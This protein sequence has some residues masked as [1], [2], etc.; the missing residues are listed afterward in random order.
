[1][2]EYG[3]AHGDLKG[4]NVLI[5]D[6][7]KALISDFGI[8][9]LQE[10]IEQAPPTMGTVRKWGTVNI[11]NLKKALKE[12]G[13]SQDHAQSLFSRVSNISRSGGGTYRWMA[14]ERLIPEKFGLKSANAT[15]ASDVFS[16]GMLSIEVYTGLPPYHEF[17]RQETAILR[18][19][20]GRYPERPHN[21]PDQVWPIV[22]HC[23]KA[24]STRPSIL[25]VYNSLACIP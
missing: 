19:I 9:T 12:G 4:A 16:F 18:I 20:A 15:F 24:K 17:E 2:H 11:R 10:D 13:M 25:S 7:G 3:F 6:K 22:E 8:A 1:M 21:I 5:S 14:P 23:W